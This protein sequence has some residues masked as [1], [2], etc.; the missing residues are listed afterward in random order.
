VCDL[1]K[2][3][4]EEYKTASSFFS[5]PNQAT[6]KLFAFVVSKKVSK[7]AVIRNLLKRRGRK[8]I[9]DIKGRTK[10]GFSYIFFF[11]KGAS[12]IDLKS[13]KE[14]MLSLLKQSQSLS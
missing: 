1:K 12:D 2:I 7:K 6:D 4:E 5:F 3:T 14:E 9:Q 8:V 13:I 11:Q 10:E